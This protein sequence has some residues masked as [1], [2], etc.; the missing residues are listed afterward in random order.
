MYSNAA[1]AAADWRANGLDLEAVAKEGYLDIFVDQTWAGAWNEVGLRETDFWNNPLLGWTF[2]LGYTLLHAAMLADTKVRHYPLVETFDAWEDWDVIHTAPQRLRWGIWAYSHA[3]VKTPG[4]LKLP[5]GSYISWANQGKRLLDSEDVNFLAAN[6][7]A[8]IADARR[9]RE[10]FGP[11]LVY[12]RESM[13]WQIEHAAPGHDVKEWIDEQASSVMKWPV[14]I[15]SVTRIEWLPEANSDLFILQTPS[16]L[17]RQHKANIEKL[18]STGHPIA[19]FGCPAGGVDPELARL[20]GLAS[21]TGPAGNRGTAAN[22]AIHTAKLADDSQIL[23]RHVPQ[24]FPAYYRLERNQAAGDAQVLCEVEGSPVLTL[25]TAEGKRVAMWD[26][27]DVM[28]KEDASLAADWGGSGAAYALVAG[29]LNSLL[30]R[31]GALHAEQIDLNQTMN[32]TAWRG[33]DGE[34]RILA[35]NL[36]EGLRDDADMTRDAILI[37]PKEWQ[38]AKWTDA[39]SSAP[40]ESN[41][42][43][44]RFDLDQAGSALLQSTR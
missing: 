13:Q 14:P 30:A 37:L 4:G 15:L 16:H 12:S 19:I 2:Q 32:V 34:V 29:A 21:S 1:S 6:L 28:F 26:P 5:A 41:Q 23:A 22:A 35:G 43:R 39:W 36:E 17:A 3:A 11:T 9:T 27:T 40:F 33:S 38:A 10:V 7:N 44:L 25:N 8:T 20:G 18:I 31:A 24:T 42:N